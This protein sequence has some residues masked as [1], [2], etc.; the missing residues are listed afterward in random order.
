MNPADFFPHGL[1]YSEFLEQHGHEG[2]QRRWKQ[3]HE[4]SEL[5]DDQ[6]NLLASFV[7]E[8]NV[9]VFAGAWC[10]DCVVQCPILQRFAEAAACINLRFID[11]DKFP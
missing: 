11:R 1:T 4:Q 3:V 7:R 8:L 9:L 5:T 2:D 6:N 10:G